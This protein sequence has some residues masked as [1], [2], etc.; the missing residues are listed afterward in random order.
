[1]AALLRR[2][3]TPLCWGAVGRRCVATCAGG[4][5]DYVVVGA[6]S[7]GCVLANRLTEDGS[8][9]VLLLEHGGD[10]RSAHPANL[11]LHM[12][13]ALSI[14]MNL[15]RY[16]WAFQTEPE[17]G[18][19]HRRMHCPRGRVLG[20]SSSINGMVFVRGHAQDF[21]HWEAAGAEGW[22]YRDCLPYFRKMETWA[23]GECEHRGSDGP[24]HTTNGAMVN[25]LY[26]AFIDAGVEAGYPRVADPNGA[27][28]EGFGPMAMTVK[29]GVRHSASSAYLSAD[30]R[31]RPNLTIRHS[32]RAHRVSFDGQKRA[33]GVVY[34]RAGATERATARR[35]VLLCAGAIGSPH[36]LQLSGVGPARVLEA[37]GLPTVSAREGVGGNLQDHLEVYFQHRCSK[38]VS[39]NGR[40]GPLSKLAIGVRWILTRQGL[41]ATNHFEAGGFIRSCAEEQYPDI[42]YHF[43]PAAMRCKA[44][45]LF[46]ICRAVRL[47]NPKSITIADDGQ[48]AL[49]GHGFQCHVGPMRSKSR[50]T[51]EVAS[52]DPAAPPRILFNYLTHPDDMVEWRRALRLTRE[53]LAQPALDA[54]RG[55]EVSPGAQATTDA[56]LDAFVRAQAESAYHP[57]GTCA[58]GSPDDPL[59][60][61]SPA[62]EVF[63]VEALRVADAS[64]MPRITNGNL[65]AP[66]IMLAE[67]L[68]DAVRG[69]APLPRPE[70]P[71]AEVGAGEGGRQRLGPPARAVAG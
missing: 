30:V 59:A 38:P 41:G 68:A 56:E 44:V 18:C 35:E 58:M 24:L 65:N 66:T 36:L 32:V 45:M 46:S 28:Q 43:L 60:V 15:P 64:I 22:G 27:A 20:G 2:H 57:C 14:P 6:G 13:T 63:G 23:G 26:Q 9:T 42:Q 34:S 1:M 53:V 37:A 69:R 52:A 16:N 19:N 67:K 51:I 11:F 31:A 54:Y 33:T 29:D 25:P 7:A 4:E 21:E 40:L 71:L 8:A 61:V 49:D 5:F 48:A 12:P 50:G 62:G 10:D 70:G 3:P 17:P 47:A 39:L 55:E